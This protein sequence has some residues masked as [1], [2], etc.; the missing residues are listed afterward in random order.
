MTAVTR[1]DFEV[2]S[3]CLTRRPSW[4][5]VNEELVHGCKRL[6]LARSGKRISRIFISSRRNWEP[7]PLCARESGR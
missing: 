4:P 6:G 7:R 5:T 3:C 1:D 2:L